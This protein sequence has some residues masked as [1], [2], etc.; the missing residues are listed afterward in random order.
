[1]KQT[2]SI[3]FVSYLFLSGLL[4]TASRGQSRTQAATTGPVSLSIQGTIIDG[5]SK[6]PLAGAIIEVKNQSGTARDKQR[7]GSDG[8]YKLVLRSRDAFV[9]SATTDGYEPFVQELAPT[10]PSTERISGKSIPL[11]RIGTKPVATTS[12]PSSST[13]S[14]PQSTQPAVSVSAASLPA[15]PPP[16]A[17]STVATASRPSG[18]SAPPTSERLTPPKTLDAKVTYTPPLIVAPTGKVTQLKAI[19]FVQS[20]AELLSDAGPALEQLLTFMR[21]K[22][23]AEIELA[24]HTDNQGD[25]DQNLLLSKQRVD[26]VKAYLV[27]NG[28]AANRI[29]TRGYGP[30]RPIASNNSEA[31]RKLNRRVEMIVVK[32]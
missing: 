5:V 19:E 10:S 31:T 26:L 16:A 28:I 17:P 27:Q 22:P 18:G 14:A 20:K 9:I 3:F 11:Y 13:V 15:S 4:L 12:N 23:T 25:F 24:G 32:Q 30:T 7:V 1:M 6:K 29:T 21:D 2:Y 8:A